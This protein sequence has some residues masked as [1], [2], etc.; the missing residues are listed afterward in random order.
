MPGLGRHLFSTGAAQTRGIHTVFSNNNY[1]DAAS[2]FKISLRQGHSL[3]YVGFTLAGSVHPAG[4]ASVAV[5]T[6]VWHRRLGHPRES[7]VRTAAK[8]SESGTV[9]RAADSLAKCEVCLVNKT[10]QQAHPK[11]T[12]HQA[13]APLERVYTN[14]LGPLPPVAKGSFRYIS[15]YT[16]EFT[17][18]NAFYLV[19]RKD[20]ALDALVRLFKTSPFFKAYVYNIYAPMEG[21]NTVPATFATTASRLVLCKN[22]RRRTRHHRTVSLN[23]NDRAIMGA[24]RCLLQSGG[25][26]SGY[27]VRCAALL[28]IL[29]N[30]LPHTSLGLASPYFKIFGEQ[31]VLSHLCVVGAHALSI[32][33]NIAEKLDDKACSGRSPG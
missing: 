6:D 26:P 29:V 22:S 16:D 18:Y 9:L 1:V 13:V 32:L 28:F 2:V 8:L 4:V 23:E 25:L 27:G 30:R 7:V 20:E 11:R 3:I 10:T 17:R 33:S 21:A 15:E 19:H 14:L 31:P 24:T 12:N 5:S